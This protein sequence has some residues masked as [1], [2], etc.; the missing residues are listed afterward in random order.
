M[1]KSSVYVTNW[2]AAQGSNYL[3]L[4]EGWDFDFVGIEVCPK[5][6]QEGEDTDCKSRGPRDSFFW[7]KREFKSL[8]YEI[9][10][11]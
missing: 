11:K 8:K 4:E 3:F 1:R 6:V 9:R 2:G 7:L 10:V 5:L